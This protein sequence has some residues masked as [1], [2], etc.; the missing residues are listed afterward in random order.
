MFQI[1][2]QNLPAS[3]LLLALALAAHSVIGVIGFSILLPGANA[4]LAGCT[5]TGLL[6]VLTS[7]A[8][9]I[10]RYPLR[11]VQTLTSLSGAVA[12]L[13]VIGLPVASWLDAASKAGGNREVPLLILFVLTGWTLSVQGHILRHALSVPFALALLISVCFYWITGSI[14]RSLFVPGA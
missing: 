5:A 3:L 9:V 2:P 8:L 4:I 10:K 14:V 13:D 1:G 12:I 11:V 6:A 7:A